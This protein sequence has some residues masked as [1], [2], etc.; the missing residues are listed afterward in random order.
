MEYGTLI[1]KICW[2][3]VMR[4]SDEWKYIEAWTLKSWG[5]D[6]LMR[7]IRLKDNS[8]LSNSSSDTSNRGIL[9]IASHMVSLTK[10]SFLPA[11]IDDENASNLLHRCDHTRTVAS[12][13]GLRKSC[14]S[15]M[16]QWS[17]IVGPSICLRKDK[18]RLRLLCSNW[19]KG[20]VFRKKVGHKILK[21]IPL[22][23]CLQSQ[24][25]DN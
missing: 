13:A 20:P 2:D 10:L 14:L 6:R 25:C 15:R 5:C 18:W 17:I 7:H 1:I 23:L 3:N 22:L 4:R 19:R 16:R 24:N 9:E 21:Y 8:I 12:C 11:E